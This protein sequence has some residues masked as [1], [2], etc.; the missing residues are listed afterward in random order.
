M[1]HVDALLIGS[2]QAANP[3]AGALARAGKRTV[4]VESRSIGGSCLN[5][6]CTPTKTMVASARMAY[7]V[8]RAGEFGIAATLNAVEM[9][10]IRERKRK[11]VAS[12][13]GATQKRLESQ[14]GLEIIFGLARFTGIKSVQVALNSGGARSFSADWIIIDT[15]TRCTVPPIQGIDEVPF[16]DNESI[17][18]LDRL[19]EHLL[20]VG[21]GYIGLEFGQMFRRFG[22]E[23]TL[24]NA[25]SH[26]LGRED[27]DIS[28]AVE[29]VL[30]EDGIE[31]HQPVKVLRVRAEGERITLSYQRHGESGSEIVRGSHL[32]LATGRAPNTNGLRLDQTGVATDEHGFI[33][34][35]ERLETNVPGVFAAGDVKGGPMFTHISYDDYRVLEANLL[36]GE[37]RSITG[38]MVPYALFID[39]QLGRIGMTE[40][41]ARATGRKIRVAK[42]P[43]TSIARAAETGE[44]RG[45]MK[46]VVDAASEEILGAAVLGEQGGE[47]AAMLEIAM[48]GKLKYPVLQEAIFAHPAWA[49]AL[50]NVFLHWE[51]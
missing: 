38:R 15:G 17:M 47:M 39:P 33:R 3:L 29:K 21:G 19:P 30:C 11:M 28:A 10:A 50:N 24:L 8:R 25:G 46:V 31:L 1:E 45:L 27:A 6:G 23:V 36:R 22:S 51:E 34:V 20:V 44:L 37:S 32:L 35:N 40:H 2:G 49:E 12:F 13:V 26:V 4:L 48:M 14:Q 41:E 9:P 7:E 16:L 42:M 43:M 18:E 5:Y